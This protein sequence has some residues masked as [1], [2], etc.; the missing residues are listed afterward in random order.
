MDKEQLDYLR[1]YQQEIGLKLLRHARFRATY[2]GWTN[3][4]TLPLG[5]DP[6][7]IVC[8]AVEDYL[9][10]RR[11][12]NP[13]YGI[14]VQLKRAV[15][16]ELWALHQRVEARA[17]PLEFDEGEDSPRG[18]DADGLKPDEAAAILH[19]GK[20]LFDLLR[21]HSDVKG[22]DELELL[23]MA[24]EE[25]SESAPEMAKATGLTVERV[26]EVR[27]K[28]KKIWPSVIAKFHKGMETS[29]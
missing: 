18:Y 8:D 1:T 23:L 20:V 7:Q 12:F 13:K 26:Y 28:L 29:K 5:K 19:D 10:D 16:S 2:Y 14:E 11:H 24:I 25:G 3:G 6:E 4:A 22:D 27:K 21:E 9:H 17:V 15:N